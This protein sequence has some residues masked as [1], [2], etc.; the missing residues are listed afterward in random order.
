L[1]QNCGEAAHLGGR[2]WQ[3]S[4]VHYMAVRKQRERKRAG[5]PVFLPGCILNPTSFN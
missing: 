1:L 4:F 5:M 3:K 2:A